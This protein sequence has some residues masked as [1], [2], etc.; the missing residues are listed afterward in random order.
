MNLVGVLEPLVALAPSPMT[1]GV[2]ARVPGIDE[3]D[4]E[5]I[6]PAL[7]AAVDGAAGHAMAGKLG[8]ATEDVL[9]TLGA[10]DA[11]DGIADRGARAVDA[12]IADITLIAKD[13]LRE[14]VGHI[15]ATSAMP[16]P[17]A[18]LGAAGIVPLVEEHKLLAQQRL[19][20]LGNELSGLTREVESVALPHTA[21]APEMGAQVRGGDLL[22]SDREGV[23]YSHAGLQAGGESTVVGAPSPQAAAAVSAAKTALGTPYQWG[24]NVPGVGLDCS[25][26][27]QWAY[28]QAGVDIPRTADAQAIGAQVSRDQLAP[29]DLVVWDGHV[30]M[31]VGD[32][33][34]IEAGDPVQ[35]NPVRTDNIGMNFLGFYR[36]TA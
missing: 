1:M 11:L 31:A 23:G 17:G 34:M 33:H 25:G 14:V 24:G 35:I 15:M 3:L 2:S 4:V 5:R 27:T 7:R 36:P 19:R 21:K 30:A 22:A 26:L 20:E 16:S 28:G 29:G 18:I 8:L 12:A 13:C 6:V 9:Q 32:G 10:G